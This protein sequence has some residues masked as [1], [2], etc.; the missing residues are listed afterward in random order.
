MNCK[1]RVYMRFRRIITTIA[2]TTPAS[3]ATKALATWLGMSWRN[4]I[5][6]PNIIAPTTITI[7]ADIL[8]FII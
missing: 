3:A 7:T 2:I 8:I 5:K 1:T 6:H 4:A